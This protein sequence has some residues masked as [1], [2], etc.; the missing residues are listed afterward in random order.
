M[1]RDSTD[2][3]YS[4]TDEIGTPDPNPRIFASVADLLPMKSVM[5]VSCL[6]CCCI[7]LYVV[8]YMCYYV[9]SYYVHTITDE[10]GTPDPN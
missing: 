7:S 9:V 6:I 8:H 5:I 1:N 3:V 4:I 10:I 2:C